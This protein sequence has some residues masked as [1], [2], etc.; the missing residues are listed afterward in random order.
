MAARGQGRPAG[1]DLPWLP[2]DPR[3]DIRPRQLPGVLEQPPG[4]P[5]RRG[6]VPGL[7]LGARVCRA[8][9]GWP[10]GVGGRRLAARGAGRGGRTGA[11]ACSAPPGE[12]LWD[13]RDDS[14]RLGDPLTRS[15]RSPQDQWA[16]T[17]SNRRP[18]GCKPDALTAELRAR[19][20]SL[21]QRAGRHAAGDQRQ[22][23]GLRSMRRVL[24][25]RE[26]GG[27]DPPSSANTSNGCAAWSHRFPAG[28]LGAAHSRSVGK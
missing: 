12:A 25:K 22:S 15:W 9:R 13:R 2:A 7:R 3:L 14:N 18:S 1:A 10:V 19:A 11:N 23:G 4:A 27:S 17:E 6:G 28:Q 5:A 20:R 26:A 16:L 24:H 8:S 21:R